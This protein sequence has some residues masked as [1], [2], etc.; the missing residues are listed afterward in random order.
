MV[1]EIKY[2]LDGINFTQ[3]RDHIC[4]LKNQKKT[5]RDKNKIL[6]CSKVPEEKLGK[7]DKVI[8]EESFL[9]FKIKTK[10]I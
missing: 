8:Y 2:L 10:E 7:Y 5:Q 3:H 1:I 6:K 9:K 4:K